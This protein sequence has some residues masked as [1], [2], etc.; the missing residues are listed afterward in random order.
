MNDNNE[1]GIENTE[2]L[3]RNL[4]EANTN[5]NNVIFADPGYNHI[6]VVK[7]DGTVY[8][9]GNG[10]QGELGNRTNKNSITPVMVGDYLV[11]TNTNRV[12]LQ[13]NEEKV[14]EGYVDYFN[15]F[16]NDAINLSYTSKD[17]SVASL[18]DTQGNNTQNATLNSNPL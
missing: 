6:V 9:W 10:K 18:T 2:I 15:I 5:I 7:E 8:A 13:E 12:V 14:V 3:D 16:N 11:R 1:L 17:S 4:P